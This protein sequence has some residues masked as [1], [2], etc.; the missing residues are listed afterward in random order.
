MLCSGGTSKSKKVYSYE[1][2]IICLP[3][4]FTSEGELISIPRKKS[5]K[6]FLAVNKLVGKIQFTSQMDE[7]EIS[8]EIRSVFRVPMDNNVDFR[9]KVLQSSGGESR[10]LMIPEVS[11]SYMWIASTIAGRNAKSP[12]YILAEDDLKV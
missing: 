4:W 10:F 6:H 2:D 9:F 3:K 1:R 7:G 5:V 12:I 11:N 8:D